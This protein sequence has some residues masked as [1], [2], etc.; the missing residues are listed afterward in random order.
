MINTV[1]LCLNYCLSTVHV[2]VYVTCCDL[3]FAVDLF[4]I[5]EVRAGKN[6]KDFDRFKDSKDKNIVPNSCFTIFYGSQF[7]L[8]TLSLGGMCVFL[9]ILYVLTK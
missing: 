5:R 4:E 6:C 1:S 9:C 2:Y 7:V 8:N 3:I